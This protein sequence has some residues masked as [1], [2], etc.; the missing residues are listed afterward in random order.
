MHE[1]SI[2]FVD[3]VQGMSASLNVLLVV[4]NNYCKKYMYSNIISA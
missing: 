4:Y 1:L 2:S 3:S